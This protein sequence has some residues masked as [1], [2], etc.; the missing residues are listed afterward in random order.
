MENNVGTA[1]ARGLRCILG[2]LENASTWARCCRALCTAAFSTKRE[3]V[4]QMHADSDTAGVRLTFLLRCSRRPY[5]NTFPSTQRASVLHFYF[6]A[7]GVR[8]SFPHTKTPVQPNAIPGLLLTI[9]AGKSP[10]ILTS[11]LKFL[12]QLIQSRSGSG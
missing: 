2:L 5:G 9:I 7:A 11:Q 8:M 4:P 12:Q 3:R 1:R 10:P 6:D